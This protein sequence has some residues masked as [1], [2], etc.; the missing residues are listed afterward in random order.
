MEKNVSENTKSWKKSENDTL[1]GQL[2]S[3]AEE[4]S[5]VNL[6]ANKQIQKLRE[7]I[8]RIKRTSKEKV[9]NSRVKKIIET[10][11]EEIQTLKRNLADKNKRTGRKKREATTTSTKRKEKQKHRTRKCGDCA[12]WGNRKKNHPWSLLETQTLAECYEM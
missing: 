8:N 2:V 10:R 7:Q 6:N 9:E 3:T 12:R 11:E 5:K 4:N 1:A